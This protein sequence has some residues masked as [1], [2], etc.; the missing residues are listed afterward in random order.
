MDRVYLTVRRRVLAGQLPP[1]SRLEREATALAP[2]ASGRSLR[3]ALRR[4]AAEG[5]VSSERA[6]TAPTVRAAG[7]AGIV[8]AVVPQA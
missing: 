3:E 5:L 4:L 1:G 6:P 7:E 8:S 2:A